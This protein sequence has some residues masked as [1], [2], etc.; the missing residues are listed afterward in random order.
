VV[1]H[2]ASLSLPVGNA[3]AVG[4]QG[5]GRSSKWTPWLLP[6]L[7]LPPFSPRPGPVLLVFGRLFPFQFPGRLLRFEG[8]VVVFSNGFECLE[9]V[10]DRGDLAL[11]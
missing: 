5:M 11:K 4:L 10:V 1:S 6:A 9:L 3:W 8:V 2:V 7:G